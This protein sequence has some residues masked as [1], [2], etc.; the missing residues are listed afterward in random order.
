MSTRDKQKP[1]FLD[2]DVHEHYKSLSDKY[3]IPMSKI[4][5]AELRAGKESAEMRAKVAFEMYQ[6]PENPD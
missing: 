1:V 6:N 4:I 5:N 3:D 2:P